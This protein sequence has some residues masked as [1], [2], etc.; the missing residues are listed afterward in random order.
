MF[1]R[2]IIWNNKFSVYF[3]IYLKVIISNKL[4]LD[5]GFSGLSSL[6]LASISNIKILVSTTVNL[7]KLLKK[8]IIMY[9]IFWYLKIKINNCTNWVY[10]QS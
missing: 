6:L 2:W 1:Y 5:L 10:N 3:Y 4:A 7:T 8:K 9:F